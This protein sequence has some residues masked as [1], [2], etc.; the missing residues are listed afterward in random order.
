MN[1]T[2]F[3]HPPAPPRLCQVGDSVFINPRHIAL[4]E[5][6][7]GGGMRVH[8]AIAE[9]DGDGN[10]GHRVIDLNQQGAEAL[11]YHLSMGL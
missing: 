8:L 6:L 5:P 10:P 11:Y 3:M 7:P 9:A 2:T 4:T 1:G